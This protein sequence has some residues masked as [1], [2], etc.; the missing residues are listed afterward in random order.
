MIY[1]SVL[2]II[3]KIKITEEICGPL[4]IRNSLIGYLMR[5]YDIAIYAHT[6]HQL[7]RYSSN[8]RLIINPGTV[9]QPFT[10]GIS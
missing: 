8:D 3:Y 10:S 4:I 2:V 6:H 7:L 5:D 9:G 1:Q